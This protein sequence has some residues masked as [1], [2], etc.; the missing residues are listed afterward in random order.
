MFAASR[1]ANADVISTNKH[2]MGPVEA[3]QRAAGQQKQIQT[4][5]TVR[6]IAGAAGGTVHVDSTTSGHRAASER[7]ISTP[8][9]VS[10]CKGSHFPPGPPFVTGCPSVCSGL[11]QINRSQQTV[12][13]DGGLFS[14][15]ER[16][17]DIT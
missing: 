1:M 6:K 4:Y 3:L 8:D 13:E 2:C 12:D 17:I 7:P 9:E 5:Q 11:G 10:I 16:D 14:I 15:C